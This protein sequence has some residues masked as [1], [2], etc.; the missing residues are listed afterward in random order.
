MT[1]SASESLAAKSSG[2][3]VSL[4]MMQLAEIC[5]SMAVFCVILPAWNK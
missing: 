3:K 1:F 4:V 5:L 2:T